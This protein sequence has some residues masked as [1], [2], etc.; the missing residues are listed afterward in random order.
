M[1]IRYTTLFVDTFIVAQKYLSV[2]KFFIMQKTW[3]REMQFSNSVSFYILKAIITLI[4]SNLRRFLSALHSSSENRIGQCHHFPF[5][6][7]E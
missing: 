4:S 3:R 6:Q 5:T 2:G 1:E 7:P